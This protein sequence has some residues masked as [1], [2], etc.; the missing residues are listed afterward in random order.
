MI[1]P[2]FV[3][4]IPLKTCGNKQKKNYCFHRSEMFY[5]VLKCFRQHVLFLE[6]TKWTKSLTCMVNNQKLHI[7]FSKNEK[8][9]ARKC[10]DH[11]VGGWHLLAAVCHIPLTRTSG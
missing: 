6:S 7:R 5:M 8:K 3:S 4:V 11:L 9:I 2:S 10:A 1:P